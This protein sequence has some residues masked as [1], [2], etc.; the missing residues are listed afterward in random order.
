MFD[1]F[2]MYF[3]VDTPGAYY[4]TIAVWW[5]PRETWY[6]NVLCLVD[7]VFSLSDTLTGTHLVVDHTQREIHAKLPA[8]GKEPRWTAHISN[9]RTDPHHRQKLHTPGVWKKKFFF[10]FSPDVS[11]VMSKSTPHREHR[12]TWEHDCMTFIYSSFPCI[13]PLL[14]DR[15]FRNG[16]GWYGFRMPICWSFNYIFIYE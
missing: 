7:N 1:I 9:P 6:C 14:N 2:L 4:F 10:K 15:G 12:L 13:I 11:I 3:T 8:G 16:N 5:R